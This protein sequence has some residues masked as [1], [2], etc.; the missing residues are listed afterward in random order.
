MYTQGFG[1]AWIPRA[2]L[3]FISSLVSNPQSL[4]LSTLQ[5]STRSSSVPLSHPLGLSSHQFSSTIGLPLLYSEVSRISLAMAHIHTIVLSTLPV[6][7]A[8]TEYIGMVP[9]K[10][11]DLEFSLLE[12]LGTNPLSVHFAELVLSYSKRYDSVRLLCTVSLP[13]S[14]MRAYSN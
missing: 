11:Q 14:R 6:H 10:I 8:E 12:M 13:S 3:D 4:H 7:F 5:L 1:H 9:D 2:R